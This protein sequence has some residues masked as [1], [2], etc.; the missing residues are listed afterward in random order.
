M[1]KFVYSIW[2]L[3]TAPRVLYDEGYY[4]FRFEDE[5]DKQKV[6][7]NGPYTF[8]SR[9]V[10]L[11]QWNHNYP[12]DMD[13]GKESIRQMSLLTAEEGRISYAQILIDLNVT[14]PL[15]EVMFIEEPN[16]TNR[17]QSST[18]QSSYTRHRKGEET[19]TYSVASKI[20]VISQPETVIPLV[21]P[22]DSPAI[23]RDKFLSTDTRQKQGEMAAE[24]PGGD[25]FHS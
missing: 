13:M 18:S 21:K 17:E 8:D 3:V 9:P 2:N 19:G 15:P 20:I 24:T 4:I 1:L 7:Q 12:M 16:G 22:A 6:L 10:V 14:Q 23:L 5:H 25:D 11:K